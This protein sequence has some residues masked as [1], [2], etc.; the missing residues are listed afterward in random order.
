ML[1]VDKMKDNGKGA[2]MEG[3]DEM[4][5]NDRK[6][7]NERTLALCKTSEEEREKKMKL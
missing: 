5:M 2:M 7:V 6:R 3:P 1:V 4:R